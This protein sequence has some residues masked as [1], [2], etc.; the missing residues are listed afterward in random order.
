MKVSKIPGLGRFGVFIDD[1]DFDTITNEEWMQIGQ[2]H[3]TSLVTVLRNVNL[4]VEKYN[5]M[6]HQWGTSRFNHAAKVCKKYSSTMSEM[7]AKVGDG[8][9]AEFDTD[10]AKWL[11]NV[12]NVMLNENDRTFPIMKVTGKKNERGEP[13]GMFAEGELLW[14]SNESGMLTFTPGVS[15]LAKE[16]M[17]GS[18]TGFM[19]TTDWYERQSNSFRS[20]LDEMVILHKYTPGKI[21]P[22]LRDDQDLLV[23]KN[24]CPV[25]NNPIP[26]VIKSPGGITGLHY[27]VNTINQVQGMTMAESEKFFEKLNRELFVDEFIYDHWYQNDND[28]M[29]FDNSITL[30]RR[31]GGN[32]NRMCYRIQY[33][34][35]RLQ[36]EPYI[37]YRQPRYVKQY[38]KEINDIV[39]NLLLTDFKLPKRTF[40]DFV[41][42]L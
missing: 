8:N 15:L 41:P 37:P 12:L 14:H 9:I 35:S 16:G 3:L 25:D 18:A 7:L 39:K 20:E 2:L 29:L 30:H 32:V 27:S 24:Q 31:L 5:A 23:Y 6:M 36:T 22:G 38:K 11:Q 10:D 21:T 4:S 19:T 13:L 1:V 26:L 40:T 33:D 34:Y 42:F 17:S 28:L